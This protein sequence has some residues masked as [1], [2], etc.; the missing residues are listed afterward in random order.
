M[1][2]MK[3]RC[4]A[5]RRSRRPAV[6]RDHTHDRVVAIELGE[7]IVITRRPRCVVINVTVSYWGL[8]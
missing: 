3:T 1:S 4:I 2:K 6:C 7:V 8:A 5:P